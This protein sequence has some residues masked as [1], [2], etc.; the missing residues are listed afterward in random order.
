[1]EP[2][3]GD[4]ARAWGPPFV[5]GEGAMFLASNAGKRSLVDVTT[6]TGA[7][8]MN[9]GIEMDDNFRGDFQASAFRLDRK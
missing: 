3:A 1:M 5:E 9:H 2:L 6:A 7:Y 4:H 8:W